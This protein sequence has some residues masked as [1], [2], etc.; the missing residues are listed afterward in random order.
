M[1]PRNAASERQVQAADPAGSTWL[2]ANA[3][4]G[5]TRV[6]TD[7]VARLLLS[8]VE[9]QRI[10]CLTYT[11]AAASEMQNR[12]FRRLGEWAMLD[13][14]PLRAALAELG[15]GGP[16]DDEVL[17]KARRLFAR[18]I[19][20]P[21][22]LKIQTIHSFC[23][24]LLRRFPLEAGVTPQF[25]EMDDRAAAL[26]RDE[27]VEHLAQTAPAALDGAA[28]FFTGEDLSALTAEVAGRRTDFA[29]TLD[30]AAA[31]RLFGLPPD[32]DQG[33][34][35]A[36]VFLG[37]EAPLLRALVAALEAGSANDQ[38]AAERLAP[39]LD[40][41]PAA[42]LPELEGVF[43]NG[44]KAKDPFCAKIGTFPTKATRERFGPRIAALNDLMA[45]VE[46]ARP[47]RLAL[48]AAEK[49]LA[50]HRFAAAFLPEY[51]TRK[52]RR[53]WLDFD[54][55]ILRAVA[56]LTDA[57]V[58]QWVL[59]RL[60]G[61]VDHIL[62]DEAQD[63]S[64]AQ[65]RV[66]ELLA[67]EFTSGQGAR[68]QNRT[69]FVVG[70]KKQS[71]YSFQGADLRAFDRM[72]D[73]FS[74]RL[75]AVDVPLAN[76]TLE[77]SFRSSQAVLRLVDLTLGIRAEGGL[78]GEVRHLAFKADMPGRVDLWPVVARAD[79]PEDRDWFDPVDIL[80]AEHHSARLAR[81]IAREL[82]QMIDSG[83]QI[84]TDTGPRPVT[85]GDVLILVQRRS[86]LFHEIIR[87]CKAE[88]LAIAGADR[89][90]LGGELAVRDLTALLSFLATSED[91]LSLAAALRSPLFGWSEG[92]LYSLAQGRKG[93]LW[94]ALRQAA[95]AHADTMTILTDLRDQADFLRPYDLLER[96]LT[97]HDGRR[98]L[99]ARLGAE[100]EDG[101][102]ALLAQALAY[103]RMAIP[104]LTG[105]LTWLATEEVEIKRQMDSAGNRIRVMTVHGAKGLEAP[106]VILP[107][108]A[109]RRPR[110][111]SEL[112]AL[113]D[114][115]MVWRLA[116]DECPPEMAAARARQRA[117]DQEEN[118][119][120]LYV[121]LTRAQSWLIVCAAGEVKEDGDCWYQMVAEGMAAAGAETLPMR[122]P[123]DGQFRRL[124]HGLWPDPAP[125]I[126]RPVPA[127][128]AL[129]TWLNEAAPPAPEATPLLSPSDLGGAKALP[130]AEGLDEAA[131]RRRGGQLH[132]LL[133]H[134]PAHPHALWPD[135]A[136]DLLSASEDGL[137]EAD[138][139]ALLHEAGAVLNNPELSFL[140]APGALAEVDLTAEIHGRR[141]LGT[142]DRLIIT[143]ERVLVVD[144][145]SNATVPATPDE[146][147]EGI[148]RQMGAYAAALGQ[149]Y[150]GREVVTAILW[151]RAGT[152]MPLAAETV[153]AAL[154]RA[155][156]S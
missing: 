113:E 96:V 27:I 12:L 50:L 151:T 82:R 85:E 73:H 145:K 80:P 64:P 124:A 9:P 77:Y 87:A 140:F 63:T 7:R 94:E 35:E 137:D 123:A 20:T 155:S 52:A 134:L 36:E 138:L 2:S 74:E 56:L 3:G 78:G 62:V 19:E 131:A 34:L 156:L 41:A 116:A 1:S 70:D 39:V 72:R 152:L 18:A 10:L 71:I 22:G 104:S 111:G 17:R 40:A 117:D 53:G 120:L 46:Q 6:L 67:Q 150:P 38:K 103:E 149:I 148:L 32:Y 43:L 153:A 95:D 75:R 98:R 146:V 144:Y 15:A 58:A 132:L 90:K 110:P 128:V 11:K 84:P 89:L 51:A 14:G 59:F 136:R 55:L 108:T 106:V 81:Q 109:D 5:K 21:G 79:K 30:A 65:W 61:G 112:L 127:E 57:S 141:I 69:I 42:Q 4:S 26:L 24:S 92:A 16:A 126:T 102:D 130:G 60:D 76:L 118:L 47:R 28:R 44:A 121:A 97:R 142:V 107:D 23:A 154:A 88:G 105:F 100:A 91:E 29:E 133:E 13:D 33:R 129:P 8:G 83:T 99:L 54:D 49:A 147:P 66:I 31:R 68:S 86:D 25:Q 122:D 139:P 125:A 114:G 37:S 93:W 119:R 101:I 135:L 48:L 45:R 143:P 115:P